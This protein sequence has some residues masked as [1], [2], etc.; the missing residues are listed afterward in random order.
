MTTTRPDAKAGFT[1]SWMCCALSAAK[2]SISDRSHMVVFSLPS[3]KLRSFA[4]SPVAPG[5]LVVCTSHPWRLNC[6]ASSGVWVVLPEHSHPSIAMYTPSCR[7]AA[8]SEM[9]DSWR[10]LLITSISYRLFTDIGTAAAIWCHRG[11]GDRQRVRWSR[12]GV[13]F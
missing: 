9:R 6:R 1:T 8:G 3:S 10:F 11:R 2:R 4:P 13:V 12:V 7:G 5:S